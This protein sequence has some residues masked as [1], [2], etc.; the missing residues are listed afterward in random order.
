MEEL[1]SHLCAVLGIITALRQKACQQ[2]NI[3]NVE[4]MEDGSGGYTNDL[5]AAKRQLCSP[6]KFPLQLS[7]IV[8]PSSPVPHAGS[9]TQLSGSCC[10]TISPNLSSSHHGGRLS[11]SS[12]FPPGVLTRRTTFL[13]WVLSSLMDCVCCSWCSWDCKIITIFS[14]QSQFFS[15]ILLSP[16]S[17]FIILGVS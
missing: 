17:Y 8:S 12:A 13:A 11:C 9:S 2:S 6:L 15:F 14:S 16:Q 3:S 1:L 4:I 7:A 5:A 10:L